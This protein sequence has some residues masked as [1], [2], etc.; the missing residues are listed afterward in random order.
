MG[1]E[2]SDVPRWRRRVL[3]VAL[4]VVLAGC[5]ILA[6][7]GQEGGAMLIVGYALLWFTLIRMLVRVPSRSEDASRVMHRT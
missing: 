6:L 4:L 5:V 7:G 1:G 3:W 2:W